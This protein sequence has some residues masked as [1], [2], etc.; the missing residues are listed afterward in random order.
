[1]VRNN[2]Q[3]SNEMDISNAAQTTAQVEDIIL[4][5]LHVE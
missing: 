3:Y 1:M 2:S 5:R 4:A